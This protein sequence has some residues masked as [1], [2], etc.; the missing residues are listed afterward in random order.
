MNMIYVEEVICRMEECWAASSGSVGVG[1]RFSKDGCPSKWLSTVDNE[2]GVYFYLSD[3]NYIEKRFKPD[4][5]EDE[6][7]KVCDLEEKI[8]I[9]SFEG[10]D[11]DGGYKKIVSRLNDTADENAKKLLEYLLIVTLCDREDTEKYIKLGKG[12]N[13][14]DV[15]LPELTIFID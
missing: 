3:E 13:I 8:R 9:D 14:S 2:G 11:L 12:K 4:M 7:E 5:D 1:I 15:E 6:A 10:I